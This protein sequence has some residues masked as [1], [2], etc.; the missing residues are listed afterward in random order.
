[1]T[2][3]VRVLFGSVRG[4]I[5]VLAHFLTFTFG[6]GLVFLSKTWVIVRFVLAGLRLFPISKVNLRMQ[7]RSWCEQSGLWTVI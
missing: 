3:G 2:F 4:R 7:Q 6:F 1:M 5:Q